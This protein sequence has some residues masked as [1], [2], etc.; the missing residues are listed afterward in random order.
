M[1]EARFPCTSG[2]GPPSP[3]QMGEV[4]R[5]G[6]RGVAGAGRGKMARALG[7]P[8][9]GEGWKELKHIAPEQRGPFRVGRGLPSKAITMSCIF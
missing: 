8:V 2:Q 5:D 1:G 6:A 4:H 9:E 7:H 3:G